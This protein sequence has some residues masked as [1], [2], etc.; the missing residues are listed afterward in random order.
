MVKPSIPG[1]QRIITD[2]SF[3]S[4]VLNSDREIHA[5]EMQPKNVARI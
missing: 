1:L 3:A 4:V 2:T 5:D